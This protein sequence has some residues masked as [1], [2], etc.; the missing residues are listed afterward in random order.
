MTGG[1]AGHL[2]WLATL[3]RE[4]GF[5]VKILRSDAHS[6]ARGEQLCNS[7]DSCGPSKIAHAIC[8]TDAP[9]LLFPKILDVA[10]PTGRGGVRPV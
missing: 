4:L 3:V 7:F 6:L 2:P 1:L 10:D 8:D 5:S 9:L